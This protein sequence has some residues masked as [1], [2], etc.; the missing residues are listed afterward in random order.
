MFRSEAGFASNGDATGTKL[1]ITEFDPERND[2]EPLS[3]C[4]SNVFLF[5]CSG[6]RQ[7]L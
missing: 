6:I 1:T 3:F 2:Q 7:L 5:V 4:I